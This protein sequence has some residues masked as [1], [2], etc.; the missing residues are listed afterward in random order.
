MHSILVPEGKQVRILNCFTFIPV[1]TH[2]TG[3][4]ASSN[5]L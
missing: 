3:I 2:A 1:A 5:T 4:R